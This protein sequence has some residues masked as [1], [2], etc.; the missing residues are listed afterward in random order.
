ME[1]KYPW[2]Y[3]LFTPSELPELP[4]R[5]SRHYRPH[6]DQYDLNLEDWVPTNRPDVDALSDL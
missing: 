3:A 4:V 1:Q 5:E 2:L 6:R